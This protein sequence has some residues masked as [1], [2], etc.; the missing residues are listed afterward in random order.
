DNHGLPRTQTWRNICVPREDAQRHL[1][2]VARKEGPPALRF[3]VRSVVA[4][5]AAPEQ[6]TAVLDKLRRQTS[7]LRVVENNDI[8]RTNDSSKFVGIFYQDPLVNRTLL[9]GQVR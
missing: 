2:E 9:V 6:R 4:N 1:F 8:A 7:C 5:V 3:R